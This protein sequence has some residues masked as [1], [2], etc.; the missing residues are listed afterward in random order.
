MHKISNRD[1][2]KLNNGIICIQYIQGCKNIYV[3]TY[4]CHIVAAQQE[5][6]IPDPV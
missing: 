1:M 4:I 3:K 5:G 2:Q 6:L